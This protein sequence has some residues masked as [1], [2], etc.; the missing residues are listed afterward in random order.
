MYIRHIY[1][2]YKLYKLYIYIYIYTIYI[3]FCLNIYIHKKKIIFIFISK[4]AMTKRVAKC[5]RDRENIE[6]ICRQNTSRYATALVFFTLHKL[7]FYLL[8]P[9]ISNDLLIQ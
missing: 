3:I 4:K 1:T 8:A 9:L 6:Y 7:V 2:L 5:Y